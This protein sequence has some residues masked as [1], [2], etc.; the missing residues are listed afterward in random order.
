MSPPGGHFGN[1][2]ELMSVGC[3]LVLKGT[4]NSTAPL[5][6]FWKFAGTFLGITIMRELYWHQRTGT[7]DDRMSCN[8]ITIMNDQLN[9][10]NDSSQVMKRTGYTK[11]Y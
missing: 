2:G 7:R 1:Y 4:G 6:T 9:E 8:M 10:V 3:Q 5:Q 11:L